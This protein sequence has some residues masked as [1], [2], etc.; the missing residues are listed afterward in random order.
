MPEKYK[1]TLDGLSFLEYAALTDNDE[2][3]VIMI[4][5]SD[6]GKHLLKTYQSWSGDGTFS[7]A[8][9]MFHQVQI[10]IYVHL[11]AIYTRAGICIIFCTFYK[12]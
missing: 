9:D 8:P 6:A 3:A 2:N 1:K 5:V 4:Y 10:H 12:G 11:Y 7:S